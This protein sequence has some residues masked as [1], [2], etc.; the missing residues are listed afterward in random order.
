MQAGR[1][2]SGHTRELKKHFSPPLFSSLEPPGW[3]NN[4]AS[5]WQRKRVVGTPPLG[6]CVCT[7]IIIN[8]DADG[9]HSISRHVWLISASQ[10]TRLNK[11]EIVP[12]RVYTRRSQVYLTAHWQENLVETFITWTGDGRWQKGRGETKKKCQFD[13]RFNKTKRKY[14]GRD[15]SS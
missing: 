9:C 14:R 13:R 15:A 1:I 5:E 8:D 12:R 6:T 4:N 7:I 2:P 11:K 3:L 10:H